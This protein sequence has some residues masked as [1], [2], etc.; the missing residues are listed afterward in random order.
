LAGAGFDVLTQEPPKNGN[1]L[2]MAK[3]VIL[4]PHSAWSTIEAR[5]RLIDETVR[6]IKAFFESDPRNVVS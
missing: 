5:Q 2:F 1:I 4:T 6:N 3:N